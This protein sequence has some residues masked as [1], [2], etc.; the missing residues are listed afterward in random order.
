MVRKSRN[1][2]IHS[3]LAEKYGISKQVVMLI[4]NHPFIFAK[5]VITDLDDEKPLMFHYFGKIR[6]KRK[7]KTSKR[8]Y[9]KTKAEESLIKKIEF[10]SKINKNKSNEKQG[11]ESRTAE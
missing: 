7:I 6:L 4:C 5:R 8:E 1:R 11:E 3:I 9:I 10:M 2:D